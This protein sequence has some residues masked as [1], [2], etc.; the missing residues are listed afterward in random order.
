L[1]TEDPNAEDRAT[2]DQIRNAIEQ[3]TKEET[4]RLK[5]AATH[6]LYGTEY[7]DPQELINEAVRRA[8]NAALGE[9]GRNWKTNIPFVAFMIMTVRGLANDSLES[10][11]QT[12]TD[13]IETMATELVSAEDALGA[14]GHCHPNVEE[15]A[16]EIDEADER[17]AIAKADVDVIERYFAGDSEIS[18]IIMGIKDDYSSKDIKDVSGMS[19]TQ[20]DTAKRRYRRGLEKLSLQRSKS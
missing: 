9:K 5:M 15:M 11:Q 14:A 19:D 2:T 3:M 16:V 1:D 7:K 17:Q 18:Y 4:Y 12:K 13:Y 8:M 6:C 10:L 20:Y